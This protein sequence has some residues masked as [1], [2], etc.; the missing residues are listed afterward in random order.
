[1]R[2]DRWRPGHA[3]ADRDR[4][5]FRS[6]G[7]SGTGM[8]SATVTGYSKMNDHVPGKHRLRVPAALRRGRRVVIGLGVAGMLIANLGAQLDHVAHPMGIAEIE[9][10]VP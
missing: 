5:V 6:C 9:F 2:V 10:V 7:A 4:W 3:A 8:Q 1:M